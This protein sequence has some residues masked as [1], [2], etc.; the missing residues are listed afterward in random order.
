MAKKFIKTIVSLLVF[1]LVMG[2]LSPLSQA[3][4]EGKEDESIDFNSTLNTLNEIFPKNIDGISSISTINKKD[5]QSLDNEKFEK[6]F[7][8]LIE[9]PVFQ[10]LEQ[11]LAEQEVKDAEIKPMW[12]P[13]VATA[14]RVLI[15]KVGRSGMKKGWA[16]ARPYVEKALKAPSKYKIDGPGGGGR[17][18]QVRLK[19][20]GKPIFRLDY[21]PVKTGGPYKLHYHVPPNMKKHHIIF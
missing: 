2:V 18:I 7:D 14:L 5:I 21:Y 6:E 15:S 13:I 19:S 4:E 12:V 17:I 20:T 3:I 9:D 16:I 10:Q 8:F 11:V 1:V